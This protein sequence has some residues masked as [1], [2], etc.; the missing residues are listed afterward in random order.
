[1]QTHTYTYKYTHNTHTHMICHLS[2]LQKFA[3][4]TRKAVKS[5]SGVC[6][7]TKVTQLHQKG[8]FI[9]LKKYWL[10]EKCYKLK[11][12]SK[13]ETMAMYVLRI[14]YQQH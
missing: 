1:M 11:D 6:F 3:V 10:K 12:L 9:L 5:H 13:L 2:N 14:C 4:E 8:L 7:F